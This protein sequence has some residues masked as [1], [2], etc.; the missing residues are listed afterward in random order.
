MAVICVAVRR[1]VLRDKVRFRA[2]RRHEAI[3]GTVFGD[4][5]F[6]LREGEEVVLPRPK[7][8]MWEPGDKASKFRHLITSLNQHKFRWYWS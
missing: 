7:S 5:T 8:E 1:G 2:T 4:K 3:F 6:V